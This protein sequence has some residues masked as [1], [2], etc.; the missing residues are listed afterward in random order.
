LQQL[1]YRSW[2]IIFLGL[3]GPGLGIVHAQ[4][5]TDSEARLKTSERKREGFFTQNKRKRRDIA[6]SQKP[7]FDTKRSAPRYSEAVSFRTGKLKSK[8]P[9]TGPSPGASGLSLFKSSK[10]NNRFVTGIPSFTKQRRIEPRY[11]SGSPFKTGEYK[12][13][14]RYTPPN[15]Q[16]VITLNKAPRYSPGSPFR[17]S[18]FNVK[19]RYSP[20]GQGVLTLNKAPRYS[21][22]SPFKP[23]EYKVNPRYTQGD[24][25]DV[26]TLSKAPRYSPGSPFKNK[27]YKVNPRYTKPSGGII[28]LNKPPRYSPPG[29]PFRPKD[30]KV[31]PRY[32]KPKGEAV[33]T[34]RKSP[35]YSEGVSFPRWMYNVKPAYSP[36]PPFVGEKYNVSP[37][38]TIDKDFSIKRYWILRDV[39][40]WGNES[41]F[42]GPVYVDVKKKRDYHP[43]AQY[44]TAK[45]VS[46]DRLRNFYRSGSVLFNQISRNNSQPNAVTEKIAK[47]KY[48]RKEREIWNN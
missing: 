9:S 19:P 31:D 14:P 16:G 6:P 10:S 45:N 42:K 34:L 36:D 40:L 44:L 46:S 2:F 47:P 41:T 18:D 32:S 22:G 24:Q 35:R 26:L 37:R 11:S 20:H 17:S 28:T 27:D 29:T 4:L 30:F 7:V 8:P 12:S 13:H 25:Q 39:M 38:Y 33:V 43:S 3:I 1:L 48:D 23:G 15:K 21:P 5:I